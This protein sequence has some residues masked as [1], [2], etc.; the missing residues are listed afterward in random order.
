M[1]VIVNYLLWQLLL[2]GHFTASYVLFVTYLSPKRR[3]V[4]FAI[5]YLLLGGISVA[6][7][8][9]PI[10][11]NYLWFVMLMLWTIALAIHSS[12]VIRDIRMG[13]LR[14]RRANDTKRTFWGREK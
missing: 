2:A 6:F 13:M 9:Q 3:R 4:R 1:I 11:K 14:A 5:F 10:P 7:M 8:A 12:N